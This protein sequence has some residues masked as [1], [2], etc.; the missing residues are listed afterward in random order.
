MGWGECQGPP[1]TTPEATL[2]CVASHR[3]SP[4]H[5]S[6]RVALSR[7]AWLCVLGTIAALVEAAD[8]ETAEHEALRVFRR[9]RGTPVDWAD[10]RIR[11][12]TAAD[13]ATFE[14]ARDGASIAALDQFP[15]SV[16]DDQEALW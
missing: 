14:R 2:G 9:H 3:D 1:P 10:I 15:A 8:L 6:T 4:T 16:A 7:G 13:V 12:A 5:R 11:E